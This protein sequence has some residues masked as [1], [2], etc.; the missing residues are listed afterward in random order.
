MKIKINHN[1]EID[2]YII[3]N[4]DTYAKKKFQIWLKV[5]LPI[6]LKTTHLRK[7]FISNLSFLGLEL[8]ETW[9][10]YSDYTERREV[11]ISFEGKSYL[12]SVINAYCFL[13]TELLNLH[14]MEGD[15]PKK[16]FGEAVMVA[17]PF[18]KIFENI[19]SIFE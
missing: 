2:V 12:Q 15:F 11:T 19:S 18:E 6:D 17:L 9:G 10:E 3:K 5:N 7:D 14:Y 8:N 1:K 13:T 16:E 4:S